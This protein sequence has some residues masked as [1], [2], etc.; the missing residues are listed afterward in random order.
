MTK[1]FKNIHSKLQKPKPV[2]LVIAGHDPCGGA[3]IQAD[4]EALAATAC[5]AATVITCLTVQDSVNVQAIQAQN[6]AL[7]SAQ[8][9]AVISDLP[10]AAV[11]IGLVGDMDLVPAIAA[12][13]D[14]I[15]QRYPQAPVIFDPVLAAGGGTAMSHAQLHQ[16]MCDELLPRTDVLTPNTEEIRQLSGE[17]VL[18]AAVA[19]LLKQG[20]K[21]IL[22]TGGHEIEYQNHEKNMVYNR[23]YTQHGEIS[24]HA[25]SRLPDTYHGSG[26]TLAAALAGYLAQGEQ[27]KDA[28]LHAQDYTWNSLCYAQQIGHGQLFPDR[29]LRL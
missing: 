1:T 25:W 13:L 7:F 8:I 19:Q 22:L 2:V 6:V 3:G 5:H 24:C 27:L 12:A 15:K 16:A 28:A 17:T 9:Q 29:T 20:C 4:I 26:C 18:T 10:I 14:N 23:L 11:K 21:A